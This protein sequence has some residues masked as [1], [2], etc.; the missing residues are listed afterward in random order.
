MSFKPIDRIRQKY[1]MGRGGQ[2][3][4]KFGR[5]GRSDEVLC[6]VIFRF[7]FYCNPALN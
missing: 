4:S 2:P 7:A 6:V 3:A 1:L 5:G